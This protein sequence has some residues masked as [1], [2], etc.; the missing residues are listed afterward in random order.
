MGGTVADADGNFSAPVEFTRIRAGRH[1]VT[2]ECGVKLAGAVD[3]IVTSSTG[4][5][6]S[7]MIVLVFF[8]LAGVAVI[9]FN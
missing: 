3:Q 8:I 6:S 1:E 5:H 9:R 2:T 4:G 7:T